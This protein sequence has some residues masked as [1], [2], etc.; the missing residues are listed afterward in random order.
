MAEKWILMHEH[1]WSGGSRSVVGR[2][3]LLPPEKYTV[4]LVEQFEQVNAKLKEVHQTAGE[5]WKN[6]PD[7]MRKIKQVLACRE[8]R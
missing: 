4:E 6:L 3:E 2:I 1:V 7:L 5:L 8:A